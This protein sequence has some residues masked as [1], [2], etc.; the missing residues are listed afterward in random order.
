MAEEKAKIDTQPKGPPV[1]AAAPGRLQQAQGPE[2]HQLRTFR[3]LVIRPIRLVAALISVVLS[4]LA[5]VAGTYALRPIINGL[6]EAVRK[7]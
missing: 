3:Y 5:G 2:G 4:S 1:P 6:T 7:R